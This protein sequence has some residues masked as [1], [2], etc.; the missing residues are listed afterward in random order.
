[1]AKP[2]QSECGAGKGDWL[3]DNGS[4]GIIEEDFD[5]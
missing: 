2:D 4:R 3:N 1:M 5:M